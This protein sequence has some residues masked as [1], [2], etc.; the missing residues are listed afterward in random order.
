ML[1]WL[2]M[3][4]AA[5]IAPRNAMAAVTI[6]ARSAAFDIIVPSLPLPAPHLV[7]AGLIADLDEALTSDTPRVADCPKDVSNCRADP[8]FF[9]MEVVVNAIHIDGR[10]YK[11]LL[12]PR[13]FK[14][15]KGDPSAAL[16][17]AFWTDHLK[18]IIRRHL[19]ERSGG[20]VRFKGEFDSAKVRNV[21]FWDTKGHALASCDLSLRQRG[22]ASGSHS[23]QEMT[24]KLRTSDLFICG[25]TALP[26]SQPDAKTKL[27]EDIS[28]LQVQRSGAGRH[29]VADYSATRSRF[30]RSTTQSIAPDAVPSTLAQACKLFPSLKQNLMRHDKWDGKRELDLKARLMPG[31]AIEELVF[32]GARVELGAG[33][34]GEFALTLWY[35]EKRRRVPEVSGRRVPDV[36]E[37]SFK[38]EIDGLMRLPVAQRAH[39]LF[40]AMQEE[41]ADWANT[42]DSSK[43]ALALP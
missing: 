34:R 39:S 28:P 30:S 1:R 16:A 23:A 7:D 5:I 24:L 29:V 12:K 19:D 40:V 22:K 11:L 25:L 18:P 4:T 36:S 3:E 27:E 15:S 26:G 13:K 31:P 21:R 20:K 9:C 14:K 38:C 35:F 2:M 33:I 41:L 37:I 10:E 43:T 6:C 17:N 42:E 8:I 32:K